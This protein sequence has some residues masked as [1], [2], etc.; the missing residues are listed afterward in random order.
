MPDPSLIIAISRQRGS[1]GAEIGRRLADHLD[2]RYVDRMLLRH[3]ADFLQ[4]QDDRAGAASASGSWWSRLGEAV[5]MGGCAGFSHLPPPLESLRESELLGVEERLLNDIAE[6]GRAV[7]IGCGA[8]QVLKGRPGVLSVFL[9]APTAWRIERVR[10][11]YG[12]DAAGAEAAVRD[13]DRNRCRF[14]QQLTG[15]QWGG[16]GSYDLT[17]D[18]SAIGVETCVEVVLDTLTRTRSEMKS[19]T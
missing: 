9:H 10:E 18:T 15:A 2:L 12:L 5:G 7:I 13:S 3:A 8:A 14:I 1:G 6:H 16:T 11:L 17:L 4:T 19:E